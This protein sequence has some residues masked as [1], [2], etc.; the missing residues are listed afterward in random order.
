MFESDGDL[1]ILDNKNQALTYFAC[2]YFL[3]TK[4]SLGLYPPM[5]YNLLHFQTVTAA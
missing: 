1:A 2:A 4:H 5:S 3:K